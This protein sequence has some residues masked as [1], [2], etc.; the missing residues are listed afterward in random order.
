MACVSAI[1][2]ALFGYDIGVIGGV[3]A[4]DNFRETM[5]LSPMLPCVADSDETNS[6]IGS[7]VGSFALAAAVGS[8][9]SGMVA[10]KFGRRIACM[11]GAAIYS[12]GAFLEATSQNVVTMV[13]G[14][15]CTAPLSLWALILRLFNLHF[16]FY[17]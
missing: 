10:D 11:V 14:R 3:T 17:D 12:A 13:I 9:V 16:L 5:D 15:V 6:K 4:M 2:G 1:G 7:I 8:T